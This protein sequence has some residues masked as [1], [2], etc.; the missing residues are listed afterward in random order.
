MK[1][2]KKKEKKVNRDKF[3]CLSK[4]LVAFLFV[5]IIIVGTISGLNSAKELY[6][7]K[8]SVI[9]EYIEELNKPVDEKTLIVNPIADYYT[10]QEQANTCGFSGYANLDGALS[11]NSTLSMRDNVFGA[12]LNSYISTKE[13]MLSIAEFSITS[14]NSLRIVFV[15]N[16]QELKSLLSSIGEIIPTKLYITNT[17][18]FEFSK[19]EN[20]VNQVSAQK[21]ETLLNQMDKSMSDKIFNYLKGIN[22]Q[23]IS[24]LFKIYD[25][26]IFKA[27]NDIA[28]KTESTLNFSFTENLGYIN[29][30]V[31]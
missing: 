24:N 28:I 30:F 10:F 22:D 7:E 15:Y 11:L 5:G 20:N 2:F 29:Y 25:E 6:G 31:D 13:E 17:Y 21:I 9:T 3:G 12:L 1:L 18:T 4:A 27:I 16:L 23:G 19:N 26:T 8:I 14:E